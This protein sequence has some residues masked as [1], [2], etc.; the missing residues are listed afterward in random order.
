MT[1]D[2]LLSLAEAHSLLGNSCH[3]IVV[4]SGAIL[5]FLYTGFHNTTKGLRNELEK[6][7][8]TD[9]QRDD[10]ASKK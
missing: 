4:A 8:K 9:S 6:R 1:T 10:D 3:G 5:F 7:I 2:P